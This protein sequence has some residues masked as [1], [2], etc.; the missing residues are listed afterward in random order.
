MV[1]MDRN[2]KLL[3][4]VVFLSIYCIRETLK[5]NLSYTF[6]FGFS[7]YLIFLIFFV[8]YCVIADPSKSQLAHLFTVEFP[9]KLSKFASKLIGDSN[10][11]LLNAIGERLLAVF[12][13]TI[14]LGSWSVIFVYTYPWIDSTEGYISSYHKVMGYIVFILCMTSWRIA[15]TA[16]PGI[17]TVDTVEQF[18]NFPYDN[19]LFQEGRICPTAGVPKLARS[20]FD[21]FSAVNV[22]KFDHFC[23]W[24][25][26]IIC[27]YQLVNV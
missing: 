12:Y 20:K 27:S 14:T 24:L 15:S 17:I 6:I 19:L 1:A 10:L 16:S 5:M 26:S 4:L 22:S 13:L 21:R 7:T 11:Q 2:Q 18:D 3:I 25:V 9:A 8:Y 23:G